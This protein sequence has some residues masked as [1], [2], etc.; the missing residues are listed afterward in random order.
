MN[1]LRLSPADWDEWYRSI[2]PPRIVSDK[3]SFEF[4]RRARPPR[5]GRALDLACGIGQ[6]TRQLIRW[7]MAVTGA[8]FSPEAI[9]QAR[10]TME[11]SLLDYLLWDISVDSIPPSLK[12]GTFDLVTC[13]QSLAFLDT[14]RLLV[15]VGRL[16]RRDGSFYVL[17][18]VEGANDD[19]GESDVADRFHRGLDEERIRHL[20]DAWRTRMT[21]TISSQCRAILLRDYDG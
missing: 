6:W 11:H 4:Y 7:G 13:R 16:L 17:T 2:N 3:E 1:D 8:D 19:T 21:W 20:G 12:P 15:D 10:K 9:E 14:N 18:R 5:G